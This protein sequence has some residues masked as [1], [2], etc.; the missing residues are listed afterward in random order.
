MLCVSLQSA[1]AR[2]RLTDSEIL[3]GLLVVAG[4]TEHANETITLDGKFTTVSD[5]RHRLYFGFPIT[6]RAAPSR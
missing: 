4:R 1:E 3:A 6:R 5:R 2:I